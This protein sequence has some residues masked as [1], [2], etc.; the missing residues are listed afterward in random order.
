MAINWDEILK[1]IYSGY[2]K[3]LST[4]FLPSGFGYN[5]ELQPFGYDPEA[6]M[7]LLKEA[8]YQIQ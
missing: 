1:E 6:A 4:C 5:P 2:G 3:R 8:G 7:S